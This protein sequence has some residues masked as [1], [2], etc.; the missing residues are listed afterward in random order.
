MLAEKKGS[1][2][3]GAFSEFTVVLA[4]NDKGKK[5]GF[6]RLLKAGGGTVMSF[7]P[8]KPSEPI[9][10][11]KMALIDQTFKTKN[12]LLRRLVA[13]G[14]D[15]LSHEYLSEFLCSE[16]SPSPSKYKIPVRN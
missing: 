4:I 12:D 9:P 10:N 2:W 11:A 13:N 16:K 3:K 1:N 7:D 15:C 8:N 5:D 6:E 14:V